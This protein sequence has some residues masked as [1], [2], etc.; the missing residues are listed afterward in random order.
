MLGKNRDRLSI[1]AEVLEAAENGAGKTRIMFKA[2]L[3]FNLLEKYLNVAIKAGFI[4][5]DGCKYILTVEGHDFLKHYQN[6]H[7]HKTHAQ[8]LIEDLSFEREKLSRLCEKSKLTE[9]ITNLEIKP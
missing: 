2:N 9:P 1:I 7:Q 6:F 3:S 5:L 4:R 8:K